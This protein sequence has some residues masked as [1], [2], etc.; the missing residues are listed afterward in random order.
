MAITLVTLPLYIGYIGAERYGVIAVIWGLLS[1]F[2][3]FD[4]GFGRAVAQRMACL[5][6][7]EPCERSSLLWTALASTFALGVLASILLWLFSDYVLLHLIDMSAPSRLE[8]SKALGWLLLT[9]AVI[10][11][12]TVLQGALQARLRF[13]EINGIL[14]IGML[15]SQLL[16]LAL[17]SAGHVELKVLVPAALV[18]RLFIAALLLQQCF[19]HVPLLTHLALDRGHLKGLLHYGGWVSV[20]TLLEPL[21]GNTDRLI[22]ATL[23]GAKAVTFYS[24]PFDLAMK[25]WVLSSSLSSAI[26][27]RFASLSSI[28]SKDLAMRATMTLVTVMTPI[29]IIGTYVSQHFLNMWLGRSLAANSARV[30]EIILLGLWINSLSVLY[31][32][33]LMAMGNLRTVVIIYLLEIP[34]YL[35]MV[36]LGIGVWGIVGAAMTWTMRG[37]IETCVVLYVSGALLKTMRSVAPSFVLV[38]VAT[39]VSL[40]PDVPLFAR[41]SLCLLLLCLSLLKDRAQLTHAVKV[42]VR[43]GHKEAEAF[44]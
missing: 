13:A 32:A 41:W 33:R 35:L 12:T 42:I 2:A 34:I 9:L 1:Y 16:P 31:Q 10:L 14:I 21:L 25:T 18:S 36:W 17:A 7:A 37:L 44:T 40:I 11:P 20:M 19:R 28:E 38:I 43:C 30:S 27:P 5:S 22:I 4:F 29:A 6:E 3:F 15:I 39:I 24:I 8:V 23:K 26:F